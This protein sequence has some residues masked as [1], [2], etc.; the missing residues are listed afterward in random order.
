[1][2]RI[3][4]AAILIFAFIT[5]VLTLSKGFVR[6]KVQKKIVERDTEHSDEAEQVWEAYLEER[7]K[8]EANWCCIEA[9]LLVLSLICA[10]SDS[11]QI[12][13]LLFMIAATGA[14]GM[15]FWLNIRFGEGSEENL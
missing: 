6:K 11:L 12:P 4:S 7:R 15:A 5:L 9:G 13:R 14:S 3:I 2:N 8:Q 10:V 1:M